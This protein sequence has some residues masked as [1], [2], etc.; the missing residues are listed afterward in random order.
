M[1]YN[2]AYNVL[3]ELLNMSESELTEIH[4]LA[5]FRLKEGRFNTKEDVV[6][7]WIEAILYK[8]H[9]KGLLNEKE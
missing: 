6:K 8:A 1:K 4:S 3:K 9:A 2:I 5:L 7:A